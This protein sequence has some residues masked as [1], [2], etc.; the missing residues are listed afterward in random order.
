MSEGPGTVSESR[1]LIPRWLVVTFYV[2]GACIFCVGLLFCG[3]LWIAHNALESE[4]QWRRETA[5]AGKWDGFADEDI[6]KLLNGWLDEREIETIKE[7]IRRRRM[8]NPIS[9]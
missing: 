9:D 7:G 4:T 1:K 2:V 3:L 5:T 6:D 8:K